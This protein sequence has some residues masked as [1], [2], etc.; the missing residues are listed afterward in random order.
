MQ[1]DTVKRTREPPNTPFH[2]QKLKNWSLKFPR[3]G[4][5]IA[6]I[7]LGIIFVPVGTVLQSISNNVGYLF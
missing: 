4:L 1:K 7:V 3:Y 2:Q 6:L 5:S